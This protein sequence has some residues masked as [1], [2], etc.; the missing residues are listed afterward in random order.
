MQFCTLIPTIQDRNS[1]FE[2]VN[3]SVLFLIRKF[4]LNISPENSSWIL[5]KVRCS[6]IKKDINTLSF[7][8]IMNSPFI[9][10]V[11]KF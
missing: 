11:Y 8:Y 2:M 5:E 6:Y 4:F 9:M 1:W 7:K 3:I 10:I